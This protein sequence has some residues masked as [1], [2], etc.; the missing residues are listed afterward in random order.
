MGRFFSFRIS[1]LGEIKKRVE[2]V[3]GPLT[4]KEAQEVGEAVVSAMKSAI[5]SGQSPIAGYGRFPAYKN[6]DRY[7]GKKKPHTPVNLKLTGQF[8]DSLTYEVLADRTGQGFNV[9]FFYRGTDQNIKEVGHRRGA[10]GQ[11]KRPTI[12][13][14]RA[15]ERFSRLVE[16]AYLKVASQVFRRRSKS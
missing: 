10:N 2:S 13:D 15:G 9:L 11:P 6:P 7:P 1:G 12:P 8:L 4:R 5:A 3:T 16:D 14:T